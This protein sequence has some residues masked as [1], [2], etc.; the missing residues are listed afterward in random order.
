MGAVFLYACAGHPAPMDAYAPL[1]CHAPAASFETFDVR[2]DA[3]P[4][5]IDPVLRTALEGALTRQGL[6]PAAGMPADVAMVA[7]FSLIDLNPQSGAVP[8]DAFGERVV[9]GQVTRFVAHVDLELREER[10]DA[11]LWRGA[12]SRRHAIVGGETFHDERAVLAIATTL[13]AM[14]EGIAQACGD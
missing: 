4:G 11:L 14:F 3:V 1:H 8:P 7:R 2:L 9:P 5:F 12:I 13:D 10:S 6:R